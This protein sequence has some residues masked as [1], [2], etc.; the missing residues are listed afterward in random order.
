MSKNRSL[1]KRQEALLDTA[2][3]Y[4]ERGR[5]V[6]PVY[7]IESAGNCACGKEK[8]SSPGKHPR[9]F[10]G[11]KEATR[12]RQKITEW[13][14]ENPLSNIAIRTGEESGVIVL[15]IDERN[16]GYNSLSKLEEEY[17]ELPFSMKVMT[18]GGGVHIY[19]KYP[20]FEVKSSIHAF[21][22]DYPGID[23]KGDRGYVVAPPSNHISGTD[24]KWEHQGDLPDVPDWL[25]GLIKEEERPP[26]HIT[27]EASR[28]PKGCRHSS[29]LAFAVVYHHQ[30]LDQETIIRKLLSDNAAL[31]KPPL[32]EKEITDIGEWAAGCSLT[33]P[34]RFTDSGNAERFVAHHKHGVRYC[35]PNNSWYIWDG[36]R[37]QPD[38][39]DFVR[40]L[41]KS[42]VSSMFID[43][44]KSAATELRTRLVKW[45]LRSSSAYS[46]KAALDLAKS[47]ENLVILPES[48]DTNHWLLNCENGTIDLRTETLKP[49]DPEDMITKICPVHY[50]PDAKFKMWDDFLLKI[51]NGDVEMIVWL[52]KAAGYSATGLVSEEKMFFVHGSAATGKSTFME[53]IK[54]VLG[55]YA[56]T[57]DFETF[58]RRNQVGG[59]RNDLAR[60]AGARFVASNEVEE[61]K[62]L[63]EG[64]VKS[65]TGGDM[66][67]ARFL[68]R[69]FF[70]FKFTGKLWLAANHAP[71][72]KDDDEAMW[73][74]ILRVPFEYVIPE[75]ERDPKIKSTLQDTSVAGPAILAWLVEG[76]WLWQEEG[77]DAPKKVRQATAAYRQDMDPLRDFFDEY[78]EFGKAFHNTTKGMRKA[79]DTYVKENNIRYPLKAKQFNDRLKARDCK[80]RTKRIEKKNRDC[81]IGVQIKDEF[82]NI[83]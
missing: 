31:C 14:Q 6:F 65:L 24:Y 10:T 25:L 82:R 32:I 18:G 40:E 34:Q 63:A 78:C 28:I 17:G 79:Y 38:K 55:D 41:M 27:V 8:C 81:W 49:H 23:V 74:R 20:G 60:L 53:A 4:A 80:K 77:L 61:G 76:C 68:Y 69:E 37:W 56:R 2:L 58:L 39:K 72:V 83:W 71:R 33:S 21:G 35:K 75:A 16:D 15:D 29:L 42:T 26:A 36:K 11:F 5:E 59:A 50:D 54:S 3:E 73:R 70:E 46:I 47:D 13:W 52:M 44:S 45:A 22:A 66:N 62:K 43:A 7:E 1:R 48:F 9:T 64:V 51:L 19:F 67:T 30:G 12:D 57:A